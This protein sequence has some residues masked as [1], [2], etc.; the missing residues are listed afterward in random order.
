MRA[1][2]PY[3]CQSITVYARLALGGTFLAAVADRFG[4][5]GPPGTH[6]VAWGDRKSTRLNSSHRL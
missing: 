2:A 1:I 5:W 4:L 6:N 3:L